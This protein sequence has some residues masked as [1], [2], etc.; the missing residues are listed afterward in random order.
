M[1]RPVR[2]ALAVLAAW[3]LACE[4][5]GLGL[6]WVPTGPEKLLNRIVM[7]VGAAL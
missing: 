7:G 3:L 4:L 2:V 1:P 5:H 6:R